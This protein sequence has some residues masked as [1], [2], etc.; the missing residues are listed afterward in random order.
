MLGERPKTSFCYPLSDFDA[1][2]EVLGGLPDSSKER[3]FGIA[4][5]NIG[6]EAMQNLSTSEPDEAKPQPSQ[7]QAGAKRNWRDLKPSAQAA[8]NCDKPVFWAFLNE[9]RLSETRYSKVHNKEA[10]AI[11]VRDICCVSSRSLLD[12]EQAARVIWH[13]LDTEFQVWLAKER[14]GT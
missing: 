5:I 7:P 9:T 8:M 13:Q 4:A 11:T 6:K 12:T 1:A 2:Y 10:A 14:I 3:W